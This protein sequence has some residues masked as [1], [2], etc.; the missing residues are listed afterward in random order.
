ME[1]LYRS[2]NQG[3]T[4]SLKW[5]YYINAQTELL[6]TILKWSCYIDPLIELLYMSSNG[7]MIYVL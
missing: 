4:S 6:Y 7:M 2:S 3:V 5:S 1:L